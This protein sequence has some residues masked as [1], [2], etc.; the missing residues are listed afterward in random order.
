MK[1]FL[2]T[3]DQIVDLINEYTDRQSV[4]FDKWYN[5]IGGDPKDQDNL[6]TLF[7]KLSKRLIKKD[8]FQYSS[9]EELLTQ[10]KGTQQNLPTMKKIKMS[11]EGTDYLTI[12]N[13]SNNNINCKYNI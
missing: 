10:L 3:E 9:V 2:I 6:K 8:I 12:F 11:E 13:N 5:K 1:A 4:A 7:F